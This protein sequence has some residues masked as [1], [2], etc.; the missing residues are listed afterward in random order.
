MAAQDAEGK[1][2]GLKITFVKASGLKKLNVTGDAPWAECT[3]SGGA[4][5]CKTDVSTSADT[6]NPLWNETAVL[7]G[8]RV[9][10]ELKLTVYSKGFMGSSVQG[11][12]TVPSSTIYPKGFTGKIDLSSP[13]CGSLEVQI[14]LVDGPSL[15]QR[16]VEHMFDTDGDGRIS[17][18]E[19]LAVLRS[20]ISTI[21]LDAPVVLGFSA[22]CLAVHVI[23]T[24][25]WHTFTQD[26]FALWPWV[27]SRPSTLMFY[28]RFISQAIGHGGWDHLSGNLTLIILVGPSC[29]K[30]YGPQLLL[31]IMF[32]TAVV[33]SIFHYLFAP[34]NAMQLG[35]SGVAFTLI[36]LSSLRDHEAGK[37]RISFLV[38][39]VFWIWKEWTGFIQN[40][41]PGG[42][43]DGVSHQAHLF[44]ALVGSI[45]GFL[46]NEPAARAG[47]RK[48]WRRVKLTLST[49]PTIKDKPA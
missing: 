10:S 30:G 34:A 40:A 39:L 18:D 38:L 44:G 5:S 26:Y 12:A 45:C 42:K 28:V 22:L 32:L 13:S 31:M 19:V 21:S 2:Y 35:A 3:I 29:E 48:F 25:W 15:I 27:Y 11:S 17:M 37:I 43:S 36:T 14:E 9:G 6:L 46:A 7:S 33:T 16:A 8:W 24:R 41:M 20:Q 4:G 1:E 49:S 47:L 23:T